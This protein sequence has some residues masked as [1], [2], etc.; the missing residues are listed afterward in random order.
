VLPIRQ[1]RAHRHASGRQIF[2]L[3]SDAIQ[4]EAATHAVLWLRSRD[5]HLRR[6]I[7]DDWPLGGVPGRL[8]GIDTRE[9]PVPRTDHSARE[10]PEFRG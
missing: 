6:R 4:E 10:C 8:V 2:T 9:L 5:G 3:D 1:L 7:R